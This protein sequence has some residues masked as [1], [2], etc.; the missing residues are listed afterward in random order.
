MFRYL[1]LIPVGVTGVLGSIPA[2]TRPEAGIW[3]TRP[4]QDPHII[5]SEHS[6][7]PSS[8]LRAARICREEPR[9][10]QHLEQSLGEQWES[11]VMEHRRNSGSRALLG[12]VVVPVVRT[13]NV[14]FQ[15]TLE[16]PF[17]H[18]NQGWHECQAVFSVNPKA[19]AYAGNDLLGRKW[20][21]L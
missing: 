14:L 9:T 21:F 12:H 2:G 13:S 3:D 8:V 7:G 4:S 20:L 1:L 16:R 6:S 10:G 19:P 11:K 5:Q 15:F 17:C 18:I